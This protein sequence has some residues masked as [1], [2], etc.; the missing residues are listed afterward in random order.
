MS[1][2]NSAGF[3]PVRSLLPLPESVVRLGAVGQRTQILKKQVRQYGTQRLKRASRGGGTFDLKDLALSLP[4][5]ACAARGPVHLDGKE[6]TRRGGRGVS[7][8]VKCIE[9][10]VRQG[11]L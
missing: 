10:K 3:R 7:D 6:R 9:P 8:D 4:R 5:Q 2:L 1:L 11:F